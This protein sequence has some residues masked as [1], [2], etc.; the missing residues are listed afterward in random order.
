MSLLEAQQRFYH[1]GVPAQFNQTLARQ[2]ELASRD[3]AALL[4]LEEMQAVRTAIR[5][6]VDCDSDL[7]IHRFEIESGEMRAVEVAT[8]SPFL[9]LQH[10]LDQFPNLR[11]QC[12]SSILGFLG[13]MAGLASDM[14]LTSQRVRSLRAA[15]GSLR[16]EFEGPEGFELVASFGVDPPEP[17][18]RATIRLSSEIFEGLRS[19]TLDPQEAFL[20]EQIDVVGDLELAIGVALAAASPD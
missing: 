8:R 14:K 5:V 1:E 19:G 2:V 7:R 4:M 18:P 6:E 10:R 11:Q 16:F 3:E 15:K 20:N 17:E 12:G 9:V 13:V